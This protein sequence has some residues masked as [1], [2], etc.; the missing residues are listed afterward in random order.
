MCSRLNR[1]DHLC[2]EL[3]VERPLDLSHMDAPYIMHRGS[4]PR[5][6]FRASN[7]SYSF[8]QDLSNGRGAVQVASESVA[9]I[10]PVVIGLIML[11]CGSE[12][13]VPLT[14]EEQLLD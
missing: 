4:F 1:L 11:F 8:T 12:L 5:C 6:R 10:Q 13:K 2:F 7:L 9:P 3:D 14:H